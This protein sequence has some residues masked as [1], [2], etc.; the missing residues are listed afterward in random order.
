[1]ACRM[2]GA[3]CPGLGRRGE[4]DAGHLSISEYRTISLKGCRGEHTF[5]NRLQ[6]GC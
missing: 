5:R 6:E 2:W 1:M 3:G 4:C